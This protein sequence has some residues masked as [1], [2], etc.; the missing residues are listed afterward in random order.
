MAITGLLTWCLLIGST[1]AIC[2][3]K[4]VS[5]CEAAIGAVKGAHSC[6]LRSEVVGNKV[7]K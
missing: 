7:D 5:D 3:Y 6:E 1:E 4:R 2:E